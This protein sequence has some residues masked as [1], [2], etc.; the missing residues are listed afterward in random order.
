MLGLDYTI[1]TGELFGKILP[2]EMGSS[3][4]QFCTDVTRVQTVQ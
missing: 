2:T 1:F 3:N 4:F